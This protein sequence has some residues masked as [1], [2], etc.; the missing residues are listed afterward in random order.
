MSHTA[1]KLVP[2]SK[3]RVKIQV[4]IIA[5]ESPAEVGYEFGSA[6]MK[7]AFHSPIIKYKNL[8]NHWLSA[9]LRRKKAMDILTEPMVMTPKIL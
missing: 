3:T 4:R 6:V 1:S 2:Q 5:K 9:I 8:R 7:C